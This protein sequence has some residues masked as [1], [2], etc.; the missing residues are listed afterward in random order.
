ML[1][2][3]I[4]IFESYIKRILSYNSYISL[5]ILYMYLITILYQSAIVKIINL[6]SM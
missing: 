4:N 6:L 2:E 3:Q 5:Y 1:K